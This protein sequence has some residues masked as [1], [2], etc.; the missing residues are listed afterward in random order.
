VRGAFRRGRTE[1][2]LAIPVDTHVLRG[3]GRPI[4]APVGAALGLHPGQ[5]VHYAT[6]HG[7]TPLAWRMDSTHGPGIGS[8]RALAIA[9]GARLGDTLVLIFD[10]QAN[11]LDAVRVPASIRGK[12]RLQRLL[13]RDTLARTVVAASLDCRRADIEEVLTK[14]GEPDLARITARLPERLPR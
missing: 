12:D 8:T 13:G 2:R 4:P 11:T 5:K 1:I 10:L 6:G 7:Q 3:S 9:S 14:R